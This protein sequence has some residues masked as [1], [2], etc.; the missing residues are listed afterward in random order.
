MIYNNNLGDKALAEYID[1]N[2]LD[3][4]RSAMSL[5]INEMLEKTE[6]DYIDETE[7]HEIVIAGLIRLFRQEA[8]SHG[9]FNL[10]YDLKTIE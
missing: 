3:N 2:N 10:S 5:I 1:S 6:A 9:Y 7:S 4:F 8:E